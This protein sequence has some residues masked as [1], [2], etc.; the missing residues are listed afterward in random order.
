MMQPKMAL[1][2]IGILSGMIL[3]RCFMFPFLA[4]SPDAE[5]TGGYVRFGSLTITSNMKR[6][7]RPGE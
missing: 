2:M 3:Y 6:K 7:I 1:D 5:I 4:L